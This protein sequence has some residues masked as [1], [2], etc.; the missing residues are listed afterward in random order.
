MDGGE[1]EEREANDPDQ[2]REGH[3]EKQGKGRK[4]KPGLWGLEYRK[5]YEP[6]NIRLP[7]RS[8]AKPR[9]GVK[10]MGITC[11]MEAVYPAVSLVAARVTA[12]IS[13]RLDEYAD[14]AE[15]GED[16]EQTKISFDASSLEKRS[17][18]REAN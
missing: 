5:F 9:T 17:E 11:A 6:R 2:R 15:A 10:T 16:K 7:H 4:H 1:A 3:W 8:K 18:E 14:T 12:M 13:A